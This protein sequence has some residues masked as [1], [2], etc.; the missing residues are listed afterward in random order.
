M[1]AANLVPDRWRA[2]FRAPP[3][4]LASVQWI[5]LTIALV[6]LGLACVV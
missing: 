5:L 1:L 3:G 2:G 4:L 6:A